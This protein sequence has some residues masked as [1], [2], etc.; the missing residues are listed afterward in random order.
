MGWLTVGECQLLAIVCC[1]KRCY[2]FGN[3]AVAVA[4]D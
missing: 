4:T 1:C 3:D 2:S